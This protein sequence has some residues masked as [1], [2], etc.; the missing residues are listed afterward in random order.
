MLF[1][2]FT[3]FR[4]KVVDLNTQSLTFEDMMTGTEIVNELMNIVNKYLLDENVK[5]LEKELQNYANKIR[6]EDEDLID[7]NVYIDM[8][9]EL[10]NSAKGHFS[11]QYSQKRRQFCAFEI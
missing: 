4:K 11:F 9:D 10:N 1:V 5:H 7:A 8:W 2:D 3:V 6:R